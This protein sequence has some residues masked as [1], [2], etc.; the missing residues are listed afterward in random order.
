MSAQEQIADI[1]TKAGFQAQEWQH[2][3]SLAGMGS[4]MTD[5]V[6]GKSVTPAIV[7]PG[8][9][10]RDERAHGRHGPLASTGKENQNPRLTQKLANAQV[11]R[12][13]THRS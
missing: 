9:Q 1:F 3:L 12:G 5:L 2:L 7:I 13:A 11:G 6:G 8:E 4:P 10:L